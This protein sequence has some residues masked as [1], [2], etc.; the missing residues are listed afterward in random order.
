MHTGVGDNPG[1][2]PRPVRIVYLLDGHG[3]V[4]STAQP[5]PPIQ[6]ITG[7]LAGFLGALVGLA[8]LVYFTG[9]A[10]M[11]FSLRNRG[12]DP[13]AGIE[14]Q[15]RGAMI[16]LGIRGLFFVFLLTLMAAALAAIVLRTKARSRAADVRFRWVL[17]GS[18]LTLLGASFAGWAWLAIAVVLSTVALLVSFHL[19]YPTRRWVW[20]WLA[21]PVAA[22]IAGASWQYGRQVHVAGVTLRPLSRLPV[23]SLGGRE[24]Q[25]TCAL[26]TSSST[27]LDG[28]Q[29]WIAESNPCNF[30]PEKA[31]KYLMA[32]FRQQCLVPYF[33]ET[34]DSVYVGSIQHVKDPGGHGCSWD[35]GA[36]LEVP[37][38]KAKVR[39]PSAWIQLNTNPDRP[40]AAALALLGRS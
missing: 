31:T 32:R 24:L 25:R 14:H 7:G 30:Q 33:G 34:S 6:A 9:V 11:W 16:L 4:L 38:A 12:F 10:T 18:L 28:K 40:I 2:D 26:G 19:R 20:L 21:L 13:G 3:Q 17:L 36:I 23:L 35:A 29:V 22:L 1:S 27:K 39:F 37:K 8:S 15:P 5:R